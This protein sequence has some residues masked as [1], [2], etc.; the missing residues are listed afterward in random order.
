MIRFFTRWGRSSSFCCLLV[1]APVHAATPQ[2]VVAIYYHGNILTGVGLENA[3][4]RRATAIAV[5]THEIVAVG[6]DATLL[7]HK[8][9]LPWRTCSAG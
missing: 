7:R 4:G 9:P 5:G 8:A 3:H 1:A 6:N 2:P